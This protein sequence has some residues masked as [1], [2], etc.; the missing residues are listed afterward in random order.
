[1]YSLYSLLKIHKGYIL[2]CTIGAAGLAGLDHENNNQ[3]DNPPELPDFLNHP[4]SEYTFQLQPNVAFS[5]ATGTSPQ[6]TDSAAESHT[7]SS[8]MDVQD[9][10]DTYLVPAGPFHD[11]MQT[12]TYFVRV[13]LPP[14][15]W[16][17][18]IWHWIY[19]P[20]PPSVLIERHELIEDG[21]TRITGYFQVGVTVL[22]QPQTHMID[23]T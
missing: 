8:S 16:F 10:D 21:T 3:G 20:P 13:V 23:L 15:R 7:S 22:L 6:D 19:G 14:P 4:E 5:N 18:S 1:M 17:E 12:I 9:E 11:V 2:T